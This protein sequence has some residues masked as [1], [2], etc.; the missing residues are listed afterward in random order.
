MGDELVTVRESE[1]IFEAMRYMR[2]KGVRRL[3]VVDRDGWLQGIVTLDDLLALLAEE[4]GE[5][6]K[7]VARERGR[8]ELSRK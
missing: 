4:M 1:G 3:R 2:S 7:L 6:N 8:E 5:M